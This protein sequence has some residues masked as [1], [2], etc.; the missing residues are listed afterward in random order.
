VGAAEEEAYAFYECTA[1]DP[2]WSEQVIGDDC[3]SFWRAR[4][5]EYYGT[6]EYRKVSARSVRDHNRQVAEVLRGGKL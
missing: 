5:A 4:I 2:R 1:V 3:D 6:S